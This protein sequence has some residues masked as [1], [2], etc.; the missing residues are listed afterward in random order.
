MIDPEGLLPALDGP[1]PEFWT[2]GAR[3]ELVL[4]WCEACQRY[5]HPSTELCPACHAGGLSGKS[6]NG[7]A[8]LLACS[9]NHQP[10]PFAPPPPY[11]LA[12]VRIDAAPDVRL[13]TRL[14]GCDCRSVPI[15]TPLDVRFEQH[16]D[17][18]LPLFTPAEDSRVAVAF[19]TPSVP[20]PPRCSLK[21]RFEDRIAIT[22]TGASRIG[23]GLGLALGE[24][25]AHA[26]KAAI[27]DAGLS[28][29]DIDG[30]A[31]YPGS[32]GMPGVSAGGVRDLV[33]ALGLTP[34]W[35][36]GAHEVA[37]Q[38]GAIVEAMLALAGGLC[39]HAVCVT[40]FSAQRQPWTANTDARVS[41]ELSWR[42]PFGAMTPA[43]WIALHAAHYL[44]RFAVSR[45]VLG[46]IAI[47][48]RQHASRNPEAIHRTPLTMQDYLA[49]RPVSTPFGLADCDTPCD[50]AIAFV[51]S[52][53]DVARDLP[54][55]PVLIEAVG[56]AIAEGQS[57]D[58]GPLTHQV[59]VFGAAAHLWS[60]TQ[61]TAA[62]VDLACLYDG[63]T[64]NVISWLEALGFCGL[65]EAADF[66]QGGT[67]IALGGD[68]PVNPHGGHLAAGRT[69]GWGHVREA[70]LQL[71]GEAH[72][73]QV[74]DAQIALTT[75]GGGIPGGCLL[76]RTDP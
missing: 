69:N 44:E 53:R 25:A 45:E 32:S 7:H 57:W 65:G 33:R 48:A 37:G 10:W 19:E 36:C 16:A 26:A 5:L 39:R 41:G 2:A 74:P 56:T 60:R 30:V 11:P 47:A 59:N 76:L 73:R 4:A 50:G 43:N 31:S 64:F 3:G 15:G 66:V 35:H 61:V 34:T 46:W 29:E 21:T 68:L 6:V 18:W 42:L 71:R 14:V 72:D 38:T 1:C 54:R 20:N 63:F 27:T 55:K 24:L 49:A 28:C 58:Q 13:T 17:V 23:R 52:R 51:L 75:S 12:V 70:V 8:T 9:I 67:R 40:T 22:G 62:E